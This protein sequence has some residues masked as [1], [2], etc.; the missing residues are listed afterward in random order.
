MTIKT[1][2]RLILI[3]I[4][5]ILFIGLFFIQNNLFN[6]LIENTLNNLSN[7]N[8]VIGQVMIMEMSGDFINMI[9]G[10]TAV[11]LIVNG[12][13]FKYWI[14]S[15]RWIIEPILIFI[16]SLIISIYYFADRNTDLKTRIEHTANT[17]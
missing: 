8:T 1:Q 4:N 2:K 3:I 7:E 13:I 14:K 11:L 15:K 9:I 10:M 16:F 6:E 5:L 12:L 17:S